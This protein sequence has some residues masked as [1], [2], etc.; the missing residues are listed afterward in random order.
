MSNRMKLH[1]KIAAASLAAAVLIGAAGFAGAAPAYAQGPTPVVPT[2]MDLRKDIREYQFK[3]EKDFFADQTR[4]L[5][6]ANTV[7]NKTQDYIN[8]QNALGKDTTALAAALAAFKTQL[9]TAQSS[10]D[11]AGALIDAHAGFDANGVVTD[12][13]QAVQTVKDVR[14]P[15]V[16]AHQTLR[17]AGLDLRA[18]IRAYRKANDSA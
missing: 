2:R 8:A 18:A 10:H 1:V 16:D 14:K 17:K 3:R 13:A 11:A 15:L 5:T 9:A 4:R 7:A 12:L 6:A